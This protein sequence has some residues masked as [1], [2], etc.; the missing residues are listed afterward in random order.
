MGPR[1]VLV[2]DA[3][4]DG[5]LALIPQCLDASHLRVEPQLIIDGNDLVRRN[6]NLGAGVVVV[7]VGKG[8]DRVQIVVGSG[9]LQN[10]HHRIFRRSRHVFPP[11]VA[12]RQIYRPPRPIAD[13]SG[14]CELEITRRGDEGQHHADPFF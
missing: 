7:P 2:T 4:D 13:G 5:H 3:V 1:G 10:H 12:G 8:D 11:C 6:A 14:L 9:H